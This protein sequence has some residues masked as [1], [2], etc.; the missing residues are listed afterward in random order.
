MLQAV[1]YIRYFSDLH[2][3]RDV[4]K[5]FS[6]SDLWMPQ[7]LPS[8]NET[9]L[10]LAGDL[11]EAKKYLLF[12]NYSWIEA[13]AK[14]FKY[15]VGVLGNHDF[16]GSCVG[17][18][19]FVRIQNFLKEASISNV[20]FLE[21]QT[22]EF[23]NLC[24]AGCTL[25]TNLHKSN[26]DMMY[27]I[28]FGFPDEKSPGRFFFLNDFL[29]VKSPQMQKLKPVHWLELHSK[30]INFLHEVKKNQKPLVVVS[31]HAPLMES[32]KEKYLL[33]DKNS[34]NWL[35]SGFYASDLTDLV[36]KLQAD[37]WIHGH[38]HEVKNYV[39]GKTRVLCNPRG[40]ANREVISGFDPC[41]LISL[42]T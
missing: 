16:Y 35:F 30:S 24:V 38:V 27:N 3:D 40:Y 1:K 10:V 9:L 7:E 28:A 6:P 21:N 12:S 2:L 17:S 26:K 31:H 8:D 29:K 13:V 33:E 20:F 39:K 23:E 14:K 15:V 37:Y 25:W 4:N 22:L 18:K 34:S 11:W 32:L 41:A 5:R 19:E 36:I 42:E